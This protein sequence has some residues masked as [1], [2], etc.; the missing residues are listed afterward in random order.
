MP[1]RCIAIDF[2]GTL[3]EDN[4]PD[5]GP[6]IWRVINAAKKEKESGS[7]LILWTTRRGPSLNAAVHACT[8]AGLEFDAINKSCQDWIDYWGE[9]TRK[10]GADEYWDD[11]SVNPRYL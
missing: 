10:V 2:D 5:V 11:R 6:P 9:D 8:S 3:F 1:K 7:E 4:Y